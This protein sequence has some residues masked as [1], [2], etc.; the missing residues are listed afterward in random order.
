MK[1]PR[2]KKTTILVSICI[3]L[4]AVF[5][6]VQF[7]LVKNTYSSTKD[8]YWRDVIVEMHLIRL[9]MMDS[10][11]NKGLDQ[12]HQVAADYI[13]GNTRRADVRHQFT[14]A[15][16]RD[17]EA[18]GRALSSE[19]HKK[20]EHVDYSGQFDKILI[21]RAGV[22]DTLLFPPDTAF[23]FVRTKGERELA[24]DY[25][26]GDEQVVISDAVDNVPYTIEVNRSAHLY[27]K[28]WVKPT[29]MRM[30]KL[31][32]LSIG[33]VTGI[34]LIVLYLL[35]AIYKQ[36]QLNQVQTDFT[37][38]VNHEL[39]TP[40]A[41]LSLIV[42]NLKNGHLAQGTAAYD[43]Q[44]ASLDRQYHKL[45][46]IVDQ[47]LESQLAGDTA[48]KPE[49]VNISA[50]LEKL[51]REIKIGRPLAIDV[52]QNPVWIK[53]D[54]QLLEKMIDQLLENAVKYSAPG[55]EVRI[56]AFVNS[57]YYSIQV[58]DKGIGISP[59][60]QRTIF[61]KFYRVPEH[62]HH[63]VKGLGL[64]L[65]LCRQAALRLKGKLEV[66]SIPGEGSTFTINL[67][68]HEI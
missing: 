20:L 37:N 21:R 13:R 46:Y 64:G 61:D 24:M 36:R 16:D 44:V 40:L 67:P 48:V 66:S 50:V 41:S 11:N 47:V 34:I 68:L 65:Y 3:A 30:A 7:Y 32:A 59:K 60:H 25:N 12:L 5:S 51:Y 17:N 52:P 43:Q 63:Q 35:R 58:I 18:W 8:G 38:N 42:S 31:L 1:P 27:I 57:P 33:S 56:R 14:M 62:D 19:L 45:R 2:N 28:Q 22:T 9:R 53:T 26:M 6:A 39:N 10:I 29:L 54:V 15:N 23:C 55:Q 49:V 4:L